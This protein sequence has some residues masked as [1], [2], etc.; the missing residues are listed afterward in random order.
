MEKN[1][2]D[3]YYIIL[4]E[5]A[6]Q[7]SLK[8]NFSYDNSSF[9]DELSMK[10]F[11]IPQRNYSNYPNTILSIPSSLNMQ[12]LNFYQKTEMNSKDTLSEIRYITDDNLVMRN[13]H[14]NG[15]YIASFFGGTEAIGLNELVDEKVCGEKFFSSHA[16]AISFPEERLKEKRNEILCTFQNINLIKDK[17]SKP[18]FIL[19]HLSLPHDPFVLNEFGELE[20]YDQKNQTIS[21]YRESYLKQLRFSNNATIELVDEILSDTEKNSIIIIQSDHGERTEIDWENPTDD[22]II[23]ALNNI[24]AY[25]FPDGNYNLLYQEM[26]PVNL[27]RIIFNQYFSAEF[28]LIDDRYYWMTSSQPPFEII[29]VTDIIEYVG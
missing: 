13:L 21:D 1:L 14:Q 22:M 9:Y 19:A 24:N 5:Y 20:I 17:T 7:E 16:L 26:S 10:G 18:I 28:E 15:Y 11:F 4:D 6:G 29:D 27:F 25:Y 3:I 23:Q 8:K 2:P 12:Y